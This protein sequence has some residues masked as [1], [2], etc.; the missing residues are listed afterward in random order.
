MIPPL[1]GPCKKPWGK[2]VLSAAQDPDGVTLLPPMPK[3]VKKK[4]LRRRRRS[5]WRVMMT[6]LRMKPISNPLSLLVVMEK[7]QPKKAPA[8]SPI[9]KRAIKPPISTKAAQ[10]LEFLLN[11]GKE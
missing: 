8:T 7:G 10:L 3:G 6:K 11:I 4:L 2:R 5:K 9:P 1:F